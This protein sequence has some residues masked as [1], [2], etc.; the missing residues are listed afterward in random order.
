MRHVCY[1]CM[2]ACTICFS[3]SPTIVLKCVLEYVFQYRILNNWVTIWF[4]NKLKRQAVASQSVDNEERERWYLLHSLCTIDSTISNTVC[5]YVYMH[6]CLL[7]T[8]QNLICMHVVC[9]FVCVCVYVCVYVCVCVYVFV[10]VCMCVCMYVC[11]YVCMCVCMYDLHVSTMY[12]CMYVC[13]TT[14]TC[15]KHT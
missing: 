9:L 12:V 13:V 1:V 11:M 4:Q 14:S 15:N 2:Y 7:G 5:M 10:Y 3:D 8:S 6:I